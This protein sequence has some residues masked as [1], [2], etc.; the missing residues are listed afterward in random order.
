[1]ILIHKFLTKTL[2]IFV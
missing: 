2:A 1:M